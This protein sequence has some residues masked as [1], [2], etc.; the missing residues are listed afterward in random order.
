M[1]MS[2]LHSVIQAVCAWTCTLGVVGMAHGG[3]IR[4]DVSDASYQTL[5]NQPAYEAVGLVKRLNNQ[6]TGT[7]IDSSGTLIAPNWVLTAAHTE[8]VR[9]PVGATF[10]IG[11][12]LRNVV[13]AIRH[14]SYT[15]IPGDPAASIALGW[16]LA[17]IQLD[18]PINT[19]SPA[20]LYTGSTSGLIGQQLTYPGYGRSGTGSTGDTIIAGTKRAGTNKGEQLGYTLNPGGPDEEV[21]SNQILFADM[22]DHPGSGFPYGNPLGGN[23]ALSFEYLIAEGDSG[24]GL[25]LENGGQY[26][27]AG[28][29]SILFD[30]D[31]FS[32]LGYGD[33]M[34]STTIEA[35]LSW[36]NSTVWPSILPGDLDGDGFVGLN[37]LDIILNHWNQNVTLGDLLQGD[38]SEDGYVG[39]D[40]LDIVLNNWNTG[41]PPSVVGAVNGNAVPE[42]ASLALLSLGWVGL[43]RRRA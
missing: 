38:P 24:G 15:P 29:H 21:Y 43:L 8:A 17:L 16:D 40:D 36:I 4:D 39:L 5:G 35:A 34:G 9:V 18:A 32:T 10:E 7:V 42:P 28:V 37:D 13:Q 2:M 6:G 27:L 25:F 33:I 26:Y 11:G 30:L 19:V 3:I 41:T 12:E 31:P 22:D 14:P 20:E 1:R 23:T